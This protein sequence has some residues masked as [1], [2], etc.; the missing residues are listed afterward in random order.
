MTA[1][2]TGSSF[3]GEL[4][5]GLQ[6]IGTKSRPIATMAADPVSPTRAVLGIGRPTILRI[7]PANAE[8]DSTTPI[9]RSVDS[10]GSRETAA[11][12]SSV[13]A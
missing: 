3:V 13:E 10:A 4:L 8:R 9:S 2:V 5:R 6:A 12:S 1:S 7:R 11:R